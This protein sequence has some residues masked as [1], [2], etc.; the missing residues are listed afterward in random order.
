MIMQFENM[1]RLAGLLM[2][3][4]VAVFTASCA[5]DMEESYETFENAS[6]RAWIKMNR[7]DLL[8]NYQEEGGYYVDV[9]HPGNME[10]APISDTVCWVEYDFSGRDLAGNIILTRRAAEARQV[11]SFTRYTHYVPYYRYCGEINISMMEGTHLAMRNTLRLDPAY[12]AGHEHDLDTE[13]K[14]REG[15]KVTLYLPSSVVGSTGATGGYEGQENLSLNDSKPFI[16]TM[17]IRDTV[18]NPITKEGVKVDA[19]CREAAN[20]GLRIYSNDKE[21]PDAVPMPESADDVNH[22]YNITERWTSVNDSTAQVYVNYRFDPAVDKIHFPEP[23]Q[24]PFEPYNAADAMNDKIRKALKERFH[25]DEDG[26]DEPYVG[27]KMLKTDS[28]DIEKESKVWYIGRFLDGFVFDTNIDEVKEIIY[29]EVATEGEAF[30]PSASTPIAAWE[31]ALPTLRYGQW[32]AIVT[33]SS[34]AYGASGI[35]GS[36]STQ[37]SGGYTSN[38]YDYLNYYNYYN[39]YYGNNYYGGYYNNYYNNYYNSYYYNN[40]YNNNYY[41]D[42]STVTTTTTVSTEIPPYTPLLFEIY[43]EKK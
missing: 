41:Y 38:Y 3:A 26:N 30:D 24:S 39:S 18:K 25:T 15:S 37:T 4:V 40:Y 14:L 21:D 36:S 23:Y 5:E 9:I 43:I 17:E 2:L 11:G 28:V 27:V 8:N 1:K 12:V 34:S 7:P 22:P 32:A 20:G 33:T 16:V 19:F 42:D 13:L 29:A 10:A 35:T 6:L 31:K